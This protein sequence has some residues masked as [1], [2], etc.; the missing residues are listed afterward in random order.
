MRELQPD[1]LLTYGWGGVDAIAA[2][3]MC[4]LRRIVHTE[5]GFLPDE[6]QKQRFSRLTARRILLR[7]ASW[8]VCPSHALAEIARRTWW[9]PEKAIRFIPNGVDIQLFRPGEP[10]AARRALGLPEDGLIV[11]TVGHLRAEKNQERL[12]RAFAQVAR[13]LPAWLL[14][15]GGG[16]L[17]EHLGLVAKQLGMADRVLFAGII[18]QPVAYYQ[19]LDVFALSSDTEQMPIALLEAMASSL[20]CRPATD[21][22]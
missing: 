19:A 11:G 1:L 20:P 7:A 21:D 3:R 15:V 8:L 14:L 18:Q 22:G 16:S 12:L 10:A 5:D 17:R 9:L 13:Y 6:A 4:G 2:G